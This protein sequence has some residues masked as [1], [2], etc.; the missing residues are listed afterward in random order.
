MASEAVS[1]GDPDTHIGEVVQPENGVQQALVSLQNQATRYMRRLRLY[2][3]LVIKD[4]K[5]YM[6]IPFTGGLIPICAAVE[7]NGSY[8]IRRDPHLKDYI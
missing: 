2:G 4:M 5:A 8:T 7:H 6:V 3:Q 1:P